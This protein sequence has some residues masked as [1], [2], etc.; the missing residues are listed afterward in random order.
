MTVVGLE[1]AQRGP[2]QGGAGFGETGP[3]EYLAGVMRFA[4]NP[5]SPAN[6]F[7]SDLSL[8]PTNARGEVEFSAEFHL[9][10]PLD[11]PRDGRLLVDSLNRGNMTALSMFNGATRSNSANPDVDPGNAY[12]F[13]RGYSVL[14]LAIQWDVPKSPERLRAYFPEALQAGHRIQGPAFVQ[15]WGNA[16]TH[17]QL[18]SDAG[19]TPYPTADVDDPR[20]TLT[21]R[22]DHDAT[23]R[24][25][26][27]DE[28]QFARLVDG[29]PV[30][31][32]GY[33]FLRAGFQPGQVYEL[34]Y[35]AEGAPVVGLAFAG[36]R[37]AASFFKHADA[38]DGNP[39]AGR[40]AFAYGWGQSMNGRWLREYLYWGCN[41]DEEGRQA[42]DALMPHIGSSRRGEFNFRFAQPS[43]NILRAPGNVYPF[44]F[45]ATPDAEPGAVRGL[46][47]RTRAN[48]TMPKMI[49]VN[50]G[51]E[52]WWS[53]ASL[54]HTTI[55]ARQ[56]IEPPPDVRTYYLAGTQH[57]PGSLPLSNRTV[58]GFVACNPI[59]VQDYRPAM[60]ALLD[61]MD[62][63]VR[64]G[65]EPPPSRMPRVADETAAS[66][67][68]CLQRI[69]QI[70]GMTCPRQLP[71]RL[72]LR[73]GPNPDA[74]EKPYPPTELGAYPV[75]V[76]AYDDDCNDVAGI[77]LPE[78]G[79]PLATYT[80]WNVRDESMG[81][82]GQMTS[83]SPLLGSTLPF[84]ATRREREASGDPR[85]SIEERYSDKAAFVDEVRRYALDL[86]R[87]RF[88]LDEDVARCVT[89]AVARW[90]ALTAT[91]G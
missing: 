48:G 20:A 73:F 82:P 88:L 85:L 26:P 74:A 11:P 19:H 38:A 27:R 68:E 16:L 32:P 58:D 5:A 72:R 12:L 37:D 70:P 45:E 2:Y 39:L 25:I 67:E 69:S 31:D 44:A 55:D 66:R 50:S 21:V 75:L 59:N 6:Q 87:A 35:T 18:V 81:G 51:M 60:R 33:C 14:S 86:V 90:D 22:D 29:A 13:R 53:G 40:V 65:L 80:G 23:P 34:T 54:A 63:W 42:Y 79:V 46:L 43:T 52:Y 84:A 89:L 1:I 4:V 91:L 3:Y 7:A 15:W 56:D 71:Q 30:A 36:Y 47:D 62:G 77:R 61:V 9:L 49:C 8:A 10:K 76:S 64:E 41:A 83:G 17:V 57:G 78:I 24:L 28:W